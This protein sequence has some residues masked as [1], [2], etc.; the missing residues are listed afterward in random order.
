MARQKISLKQLAID[1]DNTTIAIAVGVAAFI[2]VFSLVASNALWSQRGYQAEVIGKKKVALK[3]LKKSVDEVDKL[4]DSYT[5]FADQPVNV[6]GGSSTG[7]GDMD[8]DNSRIVLDALPSKYDFPALTTSLE[9]MFKDYQ[10][11]NIEGTDDEVAQA[12]V[13]P[14][15]SPELVEIPFAV[16][17]NSSA[18]STKS[19]L[20][21]FE[22]SIR[23]FQIE[24]LTFKGENNEVKVTVN[25]K[26]YVQGQKKFDVKREVQR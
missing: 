14:T 11:Q 4:K 9:K 12:A 8:G 13:E 19:A 10:I 23:P 20:S 5:A 21:M 2:I 25:A 24:K 26:T 3:E 6:I 22:R 18:S 16:T 7:S 17:L 1:K 15:G